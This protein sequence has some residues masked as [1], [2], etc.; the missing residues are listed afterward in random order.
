MTFSISYSI[1]AGYYE[2]DEKS[3]MMKKILGLLLWV[4][5]Y[6]EESITTKS[7]NVTRWCIMRLRELYTHV[8]KTSSVLCSA[9]IATK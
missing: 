8:H 2:V 5:Y 7:D 3:I 6:D 1:W 4:E 9:N